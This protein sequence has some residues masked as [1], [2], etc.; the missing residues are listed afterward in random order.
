MTFQKHLEEFDSFC[1]V[2]IFSIY[3][4]GNVKSCKY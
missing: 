1:V 2:M 4:P 3:A